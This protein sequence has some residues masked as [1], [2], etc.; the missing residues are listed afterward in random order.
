MSQGR[1]EEL[2][3]PMFSAAMEPLPPIPEGIPSRPSWMPPGSTVTP[4]VARGARASAERE[5]VQL[6][7]ARQVALS[8][9]L[10]MILRRA[11]PEGPTM[12]AEY[13]LTPEE[14]KERNEL[15]EA[16]LQSVI[17]TDEMTSPWAFPQELLRERPWSQYVR[18]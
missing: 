7:R 13:G 18:P 2:A 3:E 11:K 8:Q 1:I 4:D 17:L 16:A 5:T 9:A 15:L 14:E 6:E 12:W 10:G